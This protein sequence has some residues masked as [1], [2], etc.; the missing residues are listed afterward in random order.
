MNTQF[1][2]GNIPF[3]AAEDLVE[4]R[5]VKMTAAGTV[6]YADAGEDSVGVTRNTAASG[7]SVTV[8]LWNAEGTF[9]IES[10]GAVAANTAV[11]TAND[12]KVDD[13]AS[14]VSIGKSNEAASAAADAIEII[15][16]AG[17]QVL[18]SSVLADPAAL[19]YADPAAITYSDPA[20][21]TSPAAGTGAG[22]DGTTFSGAQCDAVVADLTAVRDALI[23]LGA[24]VPEVCTAL[25]AAG[26]DLGVL[27]TSQVADLAILEDNG[28][29]TQA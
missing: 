27:H 24:D 23:L 12:G 6:G 28:M 1:D 20:A 26:V 7:K 4:N 21:L 2:T 11:Y 13:V 18:T 19:T 8:K 17:A 14:G 22:A 25:L 10:A 3:I 5:I 29:R 9:L 15:A 16:A